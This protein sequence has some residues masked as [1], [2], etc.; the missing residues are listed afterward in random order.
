MNECN[1]TRFD[2]SVSVLCRL[3]GARSIAGTNE[4]SD[5]DLEPGMVSEWIS[6]R[7]LAGKTSGTHRGSGRCCQEVNPDILLLQEMRDYDA[8]AN[9]FGLSERMNSSLLINS[10]LP[11][12]I[13]ST[14]PSGEK[15]LCLDRGAPPNTA[16]FRC[17]FT[18][19]RLVLFLLILAAYWWRI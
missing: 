1:E 18:Y 12:A 10:R 11:R 13:L 5:Y 9:C 3:L 8:C 15:H 6:S 17:P 19:L 4:D 16:A 14:I 2:R 7:R